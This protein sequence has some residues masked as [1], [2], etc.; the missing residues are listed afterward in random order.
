MNPMAFYGAYKLSAQIGEE[1]A[2]WYAERY[3]AGGNLGHLIGGRIIGLD[4]G[5]RWVDGG[6]LGDGL[7]GCGMGREDRANYRVARWG[8]RSW[9]KV[10][11]DSFV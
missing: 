1:S 9:K 8:D 4:T 3:V 10:E 6:N 11:T 5:H 7:G 2:Q